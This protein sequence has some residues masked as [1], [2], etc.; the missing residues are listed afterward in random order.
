M[1]CNEVCNDLNQISQFYGYTAR[2]IVI[3]LTIFHLSMGIQS[4]LGCEVSSKLRTMEAMDHGT[5]ELRNYGAN[6][7]KPRR[8]LANE[9]RLSQ[10][11]DKYTASFL[12]NIKICNTRYLRLLSHMTRTITRDA[13]TNDYP[14][15]H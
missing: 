15:G 7:G 10:H 13:R 14:K 8:N 9:S 1:E 2:L 6:K 11:T 5:T 3:Y 12:F 4:S